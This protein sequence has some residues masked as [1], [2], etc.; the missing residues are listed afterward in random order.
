MAGRSSRAATR[1][2]KA[3]VGTTSARKKSL[4]DPSGKTKVMAGRTGDPRG[5]FVGFD[6]ERRRFAGQIFY[7]YGP[8][9]PSWVRVQDAAG[10][11]IDVAVAE[12]KRSRATAPVRRA[13]PATPAGQAPTKRLRQLEDDERALA[14]ELAG[15]AAVDT[16][17]G[18]SLGFDGDGDGAAGDD[19]RLQD[20]DDAGEGD[21]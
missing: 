2:E 12:G 21:E 18:A 9:L 16:E 6:G 10:E 11:W 14:A 5:R 7:W 20:D 13:H 19:D 15:T 4:A 1:P 17:S 3:P 8:T